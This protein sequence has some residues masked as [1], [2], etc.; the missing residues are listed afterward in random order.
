MQEKKGVKLY[1]LLL[2]CFHVKDLHRLCDHWTGVNLPIDTHYKRLVEQDV[3]VFCERREVHYN[4]QQWMLHT[5]S[6]CIRQDGSDW[7]FLPDRWHEGC[8]HSLTLTEEHILW[9]IPEGS[10]YHVKVS[11]AHTVHECWQEVCSQ[12]AAETSALRC[13]NNWLCFSPYSFQFQHSVWK[14]FGNLPRIVLD[15]AQGQTEGHVPAQLFRGSHESLQI[16]LQAVTQGGDWHVDMLTGATLD[17][18]CLLFMTYNEVLDDLWTPPRLLIHLCQH[19]Q[20]IY[21]GQRGKKETS[22]CSFWYRFKCK[23]AVSQLPSTASPLDIFFRYIVMSAALSETEADMLTRG[24]EPVDMSSNREQK[25]PWSEVGV[26]TKEHRLKRNISWISECNRI[27]RR[28]E[29]SGKTWRECWKV[30]LSNKQSADWW[31]LALCC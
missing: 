15:A 26:W 3:C 27:H 10:L 29:A 13:D 2:C 25:Q 30:G 19:F 4:T 12:A 1:T 9:K 14:W 21:R 6:G 18:L 11:A 24:R 20:H 31:A 22:Y 17:L 28:D 23:I 7:S 5:E 16:V 8:D